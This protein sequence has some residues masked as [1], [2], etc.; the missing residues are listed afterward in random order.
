LERVTAPIA[1]TAPGVD[2]TPVR[3]LFCAISDHTAD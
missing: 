2:R 3:S 1:T